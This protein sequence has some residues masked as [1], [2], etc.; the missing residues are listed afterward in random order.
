MNA[1]FLDRDGTINIGIPRISRV[2]S[3]EKVELLPTVIEA[4]SLLA[5]LDYKVFLV[6]NQAGIAEGKITVEEFEKINERTLELIRPS[7]I[8]ITETYY[9]PHGEQDAC[10]CKKPKPKMLFDAAQKY[11]L[12]LENSFMIG[13][14]ISDIDTGIN[15]G[16]K[17][18]LVLSGEIVE[19]P[20]ATYTASN[21]L[22]A[23][24]FIAVSKNYNSPKK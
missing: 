5:T 10:E 19:A 20:Q 23:I 14:R 12:D 24:Q 1:V 22:K 7:G 15:A 8:D 21:L 11:D 6:T 18:I 4:L 9:C 17:T 16:T 13:D 3:P 2:D